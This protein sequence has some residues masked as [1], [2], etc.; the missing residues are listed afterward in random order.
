MTQ[1]KT[2]ERA[3]HTQES[4]IYG[5][6]R[7]VENGGIYFL[8]NLQEERVDLDRW[9]GMHVPLKEVYPKQFYNLFIYLFLFFGVR[10]VGGR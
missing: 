6:E 4:Y 2:N 10:L 9:F 3:D 1:L 5:E 7:S 8:R